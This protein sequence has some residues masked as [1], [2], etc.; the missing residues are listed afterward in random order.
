MT[1]PIGEPYSAKNEVRRLRRE[2]K[3]LRDWAE[4]R[5][6]DEVLRRPIKNIHRETLRI[7]WQQV[8]DK[9]SGG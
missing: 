2:F 5:Y 4:Q 3:E 9:L 8:I 1:G 6:N 7:T